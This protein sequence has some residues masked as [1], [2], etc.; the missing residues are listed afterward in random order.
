M[1]YDIS[2][3]SLL[4]MI[5]ELNNKKKIY[6]GNL[7][8]PMDE[9]HPSWS[10]FLAM[11]CR[12]EHWMN[13]RHWPSLEKYLNFSKYNE[14]IKN[15]KNIKGRKGDFNDVLAAWS[16]A[17]FV[18]NNMTL[19]ESINDFYN[20]DI[21]PNA[22][23]EYQ[24]EKGW[25]DE[26]AESIVAMT[27]RLINDILFVF[28]EMYDNSIF[29]GI[30]NIT[31]L[32]FNSLTTGFIN[33]NSDNSFDIFHA[34][35][36]MTIVSNVKEKASHK[37]EGM[38]ESQI[39]KWVSSYGKT[40]KDKKEFPLSG[41]GLAVLKMLAIDNN[42]SVTCIS[43][44]YMMEFVLKNPDFGV[45]DELDDIEFLTPEDIE[46]LVETKVTKNNFVYPGTCWLIHINKPNIIKKA[47]K[48][49]DWTEEIK[50]QLK[51]NKK[52]DDN[53]NKTIKEYII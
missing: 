49:R 41:G 27:L 7:F 40:S 48:T 4:A 24:T 51:M 28:G 19:Q 8:N 53:A 45:E 35:Y 38:S 47:I 2:R 16:W 21:D 1:Y 43:G 26:E 25:T 12:S 50:Q 22:L 31:D 23:K 44:N 13:E 52:I 15:L 33:S 9:F 37:V 18:Q 17:P 42:S 29:H 39:M 30:Q 10:A 36:G 32:A 3:R 5:K 14:M 11:V 6:K 34:D 20:I 46:E